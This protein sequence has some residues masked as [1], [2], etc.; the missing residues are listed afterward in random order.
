MRISSSQNNL[1]TD[2]SDVDICISTNWSGLRCI[3][4]LA[5]VLKKSEFVLSVN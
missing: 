5:N 2:Q 3:K 1:G 4:T